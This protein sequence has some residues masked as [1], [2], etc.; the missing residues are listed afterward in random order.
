MSK[1]TGDEATFAAELETFRETAEEASQYLYAYLAIHRGAKERQ[2][3]L[4]QLQRNSLFWLTVTSSLQV[5][6]MVTLGRVFDQRSAHNLDRLIGLAQ[7]GRSLFS[8]P[9]LAARKRG[10]GNDP[11]W[12]QSF[13]AEAYEPTAA[14]F[15][16]VRK[17]VARLRRVYEKAYR[18]LR[19][20]VF[21]H[22]EV[23]DAAEA[24]RLFSLTNVEELKRLVV[25]LLSLHESLWGLF[26]DGR[27]PSFR[28]L[29][30]SA[31]PERGVDAWSTVTVTRPHERILLQAEEVLKRAS[32]LTR[33]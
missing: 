5:S 24:S 28:R 32:G 10:G 33:G 6:L 17:R 16:D 3:V 11:P 1:M 30:Y 18:D 7:Q 19:N 20:R 9:H 12:L 8:R 23:A 2:R 15:R 4:K 29:R 22:R 13:I 31:K 14:D 21:A 27:R 25:S 26:V